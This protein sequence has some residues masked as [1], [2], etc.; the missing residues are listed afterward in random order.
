MPLAPPIPITEFTPREQPDPYDF[1]ALD[2]LSH[3]VWRFEKG[4]HYDR[5]EDHLRKWGRR[6]ADA[7]GMTMGAHTVKDPSSN[8][9]VAI[10]IAF[11]ADGDSPVDGE[12][13]DD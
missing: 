2:V 9:V 8:K 1:A 7:N 4:V 13:P 5:T 12:A 10:E 11:G 6:Y 3:P